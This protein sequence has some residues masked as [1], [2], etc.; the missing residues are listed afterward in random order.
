MTFKEYK[1]RA[2]QDEEF[3]KEY[4]SLRPKYEKISAEI[5]K[6]NKEEADDRAH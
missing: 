6:R 4:E 2:L 1:E 5:E 3:R